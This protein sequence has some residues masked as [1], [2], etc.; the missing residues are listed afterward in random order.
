[1]NKPVCDPIFVDVSVIYAG[2]RQTT[3]H[4]PHWN[5]KQFQMSSRSSRFYM[6]ILLWFTQ[7][8]Y[9]AWPA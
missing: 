4:V 5:A 1:V 9:W 2:V 6:S 7:K 8:V 3:A